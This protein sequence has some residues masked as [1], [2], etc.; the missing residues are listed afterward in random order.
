[1]LS[2]FTFTPVQQPGG[3]IFRL[4]LCVI[5]INFS[6][7]FCNQL[8]FSN[9]SLSLAIRAVGESVF[10][11]EVCFSSLLSNL[12]SVIYFNE[13]GANFF[14]LDGIIKSMMSIGLLNLALSYSLRYVMVLVFVL[15]SPFAFLSLILQN[16]SWFF[17][18]WIKVFLSLLF[19]QL[20]I[21]I[22]LA[23]S[24]SFDYSDPGMFSKLI[25]IGSIY[26]LIKA[27]HYL[28]E[29]MGGLSTDISTGI[30]N[31]KGMISGG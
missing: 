25:Y 10:G 21:P 8:I 19:L 18:S 1:L 27:N 30:G 24:F 13:F 11:H 20:L 15:I 17:K 29:F 5:G 23:V 26:A 22:I 2:H 7:L 6:Y 9:A 4:L 12:N 3:L 16:T 28:R 31:I 14:S